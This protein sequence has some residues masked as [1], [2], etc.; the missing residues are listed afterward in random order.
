MATLKFDRKIETIEVIGSS[1]TNYYHPYPFDMKPWEELKTILSR[2]GIILSSPYELEFVDD[3][4]SI[5]SVPGY[6]GENSGNVLYK[7]RIIAKGS[8][9]GSNYCDQEG[10]LTIYMD[11]LES[12]YEKK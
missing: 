8:V 9:D 10:E 3:E 1:D 5:E 4:Y 6:F 12:I 11:V 2:Y 7:D